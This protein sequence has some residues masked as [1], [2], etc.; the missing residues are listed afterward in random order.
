MVTGPRGKGAADGWVVV[1]EVNG[2]VEGS[3]VRG[4]LES[5]GIPAILRQEALGRF[6]GI[7]VDG[8]GK[9]EILVPPSC[10]ERALEILSS[11]GNPGEKTR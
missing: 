11:V 7:S 5:E 6:Y 3:I 10:E 4:K 2:S 8:L 1:C 9:V